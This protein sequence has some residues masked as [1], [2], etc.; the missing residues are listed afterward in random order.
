MSALPLNSIALERTVEA[1]LNSPAST[2]PT[3]ALVDEL[4]HTHAQAMD[5]S[6]PDPFR[7]AVSRALGLNSAPWPDTQDHDDHQD[8]DHADTLTAAVHAALNR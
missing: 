8:D 1:R 5:Q 2:A 4:A 7:D 3:D 6:R